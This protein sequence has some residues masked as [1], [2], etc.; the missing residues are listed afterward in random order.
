MNQK[1]FN[2]ILAL[3]R[4]GVHLETGI[5][6]VLNLSQ[7]TGSDPTT[8]LSKLFS[9]QFQ[10]KLDEWRRKEVSNDCPKN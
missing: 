7:K 3:M 9:A 10:M 4:Q 2:S 1:Q 5:Q 6:M 8:W